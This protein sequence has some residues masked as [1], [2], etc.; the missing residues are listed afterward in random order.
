MAEAQVKRDKKGAAEEKKKKE[1]H[2]HFGFSGHHEK[3]AST[4]SGKA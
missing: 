4:S 3:P 1:K 2:G